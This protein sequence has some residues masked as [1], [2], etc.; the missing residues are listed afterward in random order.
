MSAT[1]K[2]NKINQFKDAHQNSKEGYAL[3][4]KPSGSLKNLLEAHKIDTSPSDQLSAIMGLGG[5]RDKE[6]WAQAAGLVFDLYEWDGHE[7]DKKHIDQKIHEK[8]VELGVLNSLWYLSDDNEQEISD[9]MHELNSLSIKQ[10]CALWVRREIEEVALI[11][12]DWVHEQS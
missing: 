5:E 11:L 7:A 8:V 4:I 9:A 3:F 6:I 12:N 2:S 1:N 10:A